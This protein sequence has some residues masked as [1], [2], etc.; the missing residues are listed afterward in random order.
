MNKLYAK[1]FDG[2]SIVAKTIMDLNPMSE[3]IIEVKKKTKSRSVNQN[4]LYWEHVT[5]IGNH[6]GSFKEDA[7]QDLMQ[8]LTKAT[9]EKVN[10]I[11]GKTE[12]AWSLKKMPKDQMSDY[13]TKL[14]I[15]ANGEG[16]FLRCPEEQQRRD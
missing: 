2:L 10:P 6:F 5:T 8:H 13:M 9:H 4:S 11:T 3:W 7:H 15:W 16:I 14:I 1:G 12:S